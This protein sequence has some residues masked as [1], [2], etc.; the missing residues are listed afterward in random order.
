MMRNLRNILIPAIG[1][2]GAFLAVKYLL[3]LIL[4]FLLGAALAFT[5]EPVVQFLCA[6][7]HLKRGL[8]AGIGVSMAFSFLAFAVL[9]LCGLILRQLRALAGILPGLEQTELDGMRAIL[10][11]NVIDLFSSGSALLEQVTSYLLRL[12]SGILSQVPDS[13]LT[14][15]TAI[16]SSFMISAKLPR[17]RQY[18]SRRLSTQR[19]SSIRATL[20]R[21]RSALGGW[22]KAQAK[23]SG[24]TL[25]I[26]TVGFLLLGI[27]YAPLAAAAVALVDAFPVLGTGTVLLPWSLVAFLRGERLLCFGLL[28][29]YAAVSLTRSVLEPRLVGKQLGLDPLTTLAAIYIG[30][31]LWGLGGMIL[32]PML[33]VAAAQ[34]LPAVRPNP[35][36]Q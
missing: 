12:A 16:V 22:L 26:L 32:A 24:V 30:Y 31:Q 33:A 8:A 25:L 1:L 11:R 17:I 5:A 10:K 15:G 20:T 6:R 19:Q 13:A 7:L 27:R 4:P 9:I 2:L 29:V 18:L 35:E 34:F 36:A 23:L 28:G 21:L 14:I 3:P